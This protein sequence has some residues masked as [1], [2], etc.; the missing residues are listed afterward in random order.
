MIPEPFDPTQDPLDSAN[1]ATRAAWTAA[2]EA[3]ERGDL[4]R[5][6]ECLLEA[7]DSAAGDLELEDR[8]ECSLAAVQ[9]ELGETVSREQLRAILMRARTPVVLHLAAYQIG[10]MFEIA[11]AAKKA[12]FYAQVSLDNGRRT[13]RCELEARARNLVGNALCADS[14][15]ADAREEYRAA[16]AL[17]AEPGTPWHAMLHENVGYCDVVLGDLKEGLRRLYSSLRQLRRLGAARFQTTARID[18]AYALLAAERPALALRHLQFAIAGAERFADTRSLRNALFLQA[19]AATR[20]GNLFAARRACQR[21]SELTGSPD[22]AEFLLHT[23][24]LELLN[25]RA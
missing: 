5:S 4:Q 15:F 22:V 21:L 17:E 24:V 2:V 16:L 11:G 12:L 7:R 14:Y 20:L 9:L 25:L 19:E 10:R 1:A 18:L 8:L 3:L 13:G 23:D 6:R